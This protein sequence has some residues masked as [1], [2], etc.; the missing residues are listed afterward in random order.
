MCLYT[1]N[2]EPKIAE[3]DIPCYKELVCSGKRYITP[4]M[5][6]PVFRSNSNRISGKR[7][8]AKPRRKVNWFSCRYTGCRYGIDKGA[9]HVYSKYNG[10]RCVINSEVF[11]AY[12]PKGTKYWVSVDGTQYAAKKIVLTGRRMP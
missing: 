11:E 5:Q 1:N 9:I 12:I 6:L 8:V 3:E 4:F 2:I 10:D 7:V